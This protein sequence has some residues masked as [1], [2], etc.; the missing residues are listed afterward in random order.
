[1]GSSSPKTHMTPPDLASYPG[2]DEDQ[3]G[4]LRHIHNLAAQ[5][6]GDWSRMGDGDP[7]Q[8][9]FSAYRFQLAYMAYALG[10]A[11]RHR[12]PAARE[13]MRQTFQLLIEKMLRRD[14][15]SYWKDISRSSPRLD[16]DL[17]GLRPSVT[18]PIGRENI[19]YSGHLHAMAGLYAVL[20]DDDRFAAPGALTVSQSSRLWGLGPETYA[21]DFR[22]LNE[23]IYWQMVE[24]GWLGVACEPNCIFIVC[25]QFPMLGFRFHDLRHGTAIAEEA[26]ESYR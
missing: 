18:D 22:K 14:V 8:E 3:R 1:M 12:L 26:T 10:L 17:V 23:T 13:P 2:L 15:W 24:N 16:P 7:A 11:Y 19:M 5:L 20:F 4:H 21:Y 9:S 6:P 25:N